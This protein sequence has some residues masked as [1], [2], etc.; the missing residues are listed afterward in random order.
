MCLPIPLKN[1]NVPIH[2][3][4]RKQVYPL[5]PPLSLTVCCGVYMYILYMH[6]CFFYVRA[7]PS[8]HLYIYIYI[9]FFVR[10][11]AALQQSAIQEH[12]LYIDSASQGHP[13]SPAGSP[14]RTHR[15]AGIADGLRPNAENGAP[16]PVRKMGSNSYLL[17]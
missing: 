15:A 11:L 12:V 3:P 4:I 10:S 16:D 14:S 7:N 9:L 13:A 2:P 1:D 17:R 8:E 6:P 5:Q